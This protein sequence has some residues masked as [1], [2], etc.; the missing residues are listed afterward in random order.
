MLTEEEF[1]DARRALPADLPESRHAPRRAARAHEPPR[2]QAGARPSRRPRERRRAAAPRLLARVQPRLAHARADALPGAALRSRPRAARA[3]QGRT[4]ADRRRR[5]SRCRH[6]PGRG[7]ARPVRPRRALRDARRAVRPLPEHRHGGRR[8]LRAGASHRDD[9][10]ARA[11]RRSRRVRP[12]ASSPCADGRPTRRAAAAPR[13][14]RVGSGA[15]RRRSPG[16]AR[17]ACC[18][19]STAAGARARLGGARPQRPQGRASRSA[20]GASAATPTS[21]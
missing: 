17:T 12:T 9:G 4:G 7:A 1:A 21:A 3:R 6:P 11:W 10:P 14:R 18:R 19:P 2:R 20:P 5:A 16:D 13:S 8:G 15:R